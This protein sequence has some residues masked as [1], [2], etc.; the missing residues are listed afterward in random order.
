MNYILTG[1]VGFIGSRIAEILSKGHD[2]TFIDPI[3]SGKKSII[4]SLP[5]QFEEGSKLR[6]TTHPKVISEAD[7]IHFCVPTTVIKA[8]DPDP[9]PVKSAARTVG[10]NLKK[11]AVVVLESTIYPGATEEI[12]FPILEQESGMVCGKDFSVGYSPE[13]INPNDDEHTLEKTTKIVSEMDE[14]TTD[15]L[16]EVYGLV[17]MV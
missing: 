4:S 15:L 10:Q 2:V 6:T 13:R 3:F 7:I 14:M 16:C 12:V 1:G 11:G 17:T 5:A 8:K 9:C